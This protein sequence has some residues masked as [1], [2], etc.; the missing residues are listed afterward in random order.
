[1]KNSILA[2]CIIFCINT[3]KAQDTS[4]VDKAHVEISLGGKDGVCVK[5]GGKNIIGKRSKEKNNKTSNTLGFDLG[6]NNFDNS[7]VNG[8]DYTIAYPSTTNT[9]TYGASNSLEINNTKSMNVNIYPLY[10]SFHLY[11]KSINLITGLGFNYYN[12]RYKND[13]TMQEWHTITNFPV[14]AYNNNVHT[15]KKS[16]VAASYLTVPLM[17]QFKPNIGNKKALVMGGGVSVG[18]LMKGWYKTKTAADGKSKENI[19]FAFNPL[20]INAIGEFGIDDKLRFYGSYGL[21]SLYKTKL[22]Q[23]QAIAVGIRIF[24]L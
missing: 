5:K 24:G 10:Y 16:K 1:M 12:F 21:T 18:Y 3:A 2:L 11:K 23:Q 9:G 8:F 4:K 20:Q 6:F 19:G 14:L 15:P 7:N 13:I 22:P 17:L